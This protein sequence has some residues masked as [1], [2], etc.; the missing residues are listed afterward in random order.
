[1]L[2]ICYTKASGTNKALYG[3]F[4]PWACYFRNYNTAPG[5]YYAKRRGYAANT[6]IS[7]YRFN[8]LRTD[9][10]SNIEWHHELGWITGGSYLHRGGH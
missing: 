6:D 10:G 7:Q 2:Q 8:R 1:M 3:G 9:N 5:S 4:G